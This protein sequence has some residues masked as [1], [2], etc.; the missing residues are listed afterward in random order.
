MPGRIIDK[1]KQQTV[2]HNLT[3]TIISTT[4]INA[5]EQH[6]VHIGEILHC[7]RERDNPHD[8]CAVGV[9]NESGSLVGHVPIELS[10]IFSRFLGDYGEL[11]AECI[12][13]RFNP[14]LVGGGANLP[15]LVDF[16]N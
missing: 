15:P 1:R 16:F 12:G 5:C 2:I 9:Y 10:A 11:E 4:N 6:D 7:E 13:S 14:I 8:I 3:G